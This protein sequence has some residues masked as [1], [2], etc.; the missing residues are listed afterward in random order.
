MSIM[1]EA[2]AICEAEKGAGRVMDDSSAKRAITSDELDVI[3]RLSAAVRGDFAEM[4]G[5]TKNDRPVAYMQSQ[6]AAITTMFISQAFIIDELLKRI[7][8]LEAR[9]TAE[10]R[11]VWQGNESYKIG[12]LVTHAGGMWSAVAV[13]KGLRP[14]SAPVAW[15]LAVKR[16]AVG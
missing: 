15:R 10:L 8:A 2:E 9:P 13:S 6:H 5:L 4:R 3:K 7:V 11:G 16:G 12:D 1:T 14:G